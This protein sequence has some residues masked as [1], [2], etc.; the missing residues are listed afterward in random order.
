M[1]DLDGRI[2]SGCVS[3]PIL[4]AWITNDGGTGTCEGCGSEAPSIAIEM[5]KWRIDEAFKS[6][7]RPGPGP[8]AATIFAR[9]AGIGETLA[10]LL[11]EDL[12]E[13]Y[14]Q[15]AARGKTDDPYDAEGFVEDGP[16]DPPDDGRWH[17]FQRTIRREARYFNTDAE[18]WL[19]DIFTGLN[20]QR[21]WN[22]DS[23]IVDIAVVTAGNGF[24][25]ARYAPNDAK[26]AEILSDPISQLGPPP[27]GTATAGRMNAAGLSVFYGAI[28]R[29]TCLSEIR[30]PVGSSVVIGRFNPIRPIRLLDLDRLSRVAYNGSH[31][32][33]DYW[34]KRNRVYILPAIV[35]RIARPIMPGDEAFG[36]LPTQFVADYLA[37]RL[38]PKID[39]VLFASTQTDGVGQNVVLFNRAC[40]VESLAPT[41]ELSLDCGWNEPREMG[42]WLAL[43]LSKRTTPKS[44]SPLVDWDDERKAFLRLDLSS[45]EVR[46]IRATKY[47]A[48]LRRNY[49][50]TKR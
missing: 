39:G 45:I 50:F 9:I 40:R 17:A 19:D 30:A 42:D 46:E 13:T 28:D 4:H 25:R 10:E 3:D 22:G 41:L 12:A 27:N 5:L 7:F 14:G 38:E 16:D 21:T 29:E 24:F 6:Q 49:S 8:E 31:F 11:A 2:C 33:E 20:D 34:G 48:P 26:L 36:Y 23:V 15:L 43:T 44:L 32:D 37:Q 1:I 47:E 35:R 18:S